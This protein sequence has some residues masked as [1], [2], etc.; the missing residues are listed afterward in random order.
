L[1]AQGREELNRVDTKAS[2]LLAAV[3]VALGAVVG[4]LATR[5]WSPFRLPLVLALVWWVGVAAA[6][7]GITCLLA[8][9]Y[10]RHRQLVTPS[11]GGPHGY[12]GY[13]ADI[14]T[15]RSAAEV[16]RAI[17]RSSRRDLDLISE[18]LLQVSRIVHRKYRLL[19]LG[20]W[21][22]T[23]GVACGIVALLLSI[24]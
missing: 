11:A 9:V 20:I 2:I 13:Y 4:G 16:T 17:I 19:G 12:V 8:A 14:A 24:A 21:L 10:P 15:Y 5:G 23:V 18:Q 7:A 1:L 6:G 22:V 3:G